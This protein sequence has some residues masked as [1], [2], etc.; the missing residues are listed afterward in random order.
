[1]RFFAACSCRFYGTFS[2][3]EN[4]LVLYC[5]RHAPVT[6]R[7]A[8]WATL[9]QGTR[10]REL[11]CDRTRPRCAAPGCAASDER[12]IGESLIAQE[13]YEA[14]LADKGFAGVRWERH[15]LESYGTLVAATSKDNSKRRW[16]ASDHR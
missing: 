10:T 12:P 6:L 4:L 1:M 7:G 13:S 5:S 16:S 14:Y 8:I 3:P 15:W 11:A 2:A 9:G